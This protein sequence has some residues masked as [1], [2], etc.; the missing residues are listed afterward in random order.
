MRRVLMLGC[1]WLLVVVGVVHFARQETPLSPWIYIER[2]RQLHLIRWDGSHEK[3]L[4]LKDFTFV[5]TSPDGEWILWTKKTEHDLYLSRRS[6]TETYF[7]ATLV[8]ASQWSPD[9]KQIAMV[10]NS[11]LTIY[12][13]ETHTWESLDIPTNREFH[14]EWFPNGRRLI[15]RGS[16]DGEFDLFSIR[17]DSTDFRRYQI[18]D[19][20]HAILSELSPTGEMVAMSHSAD[21]SPRDVFV[22][23]V[24]SGMLRNLTNTPDI[25]ENFRLWDAH[26]EWIYFDVNRNIFRI[27]PD[28][29]ET[30]PFFDFPIYPV[31]NRFGDWIVY[32]DNNVMSPNSDT[33]IV[34]YNLRTHK[35]IPLVSVVLQ[36]TM[37]PVIIPPADLN[38]HPETLA[39]GAALILG[40]AAITNIRRRRLA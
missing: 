39:I 36:E 5:T 31:P 6:L 1:V 25:S 33:D 38:W 26:G 29:S 28:G 8:E 7:L 20:A 24:D 11:R 14:P 13:I 21:E 9:S 30:Q 40:T 3:A 4:P 23:S 12:D 37:N 16:L 27:R 15:F 19:F 17:L 18:G 35:R 2:D 32:K 22:M 34:R 10:V